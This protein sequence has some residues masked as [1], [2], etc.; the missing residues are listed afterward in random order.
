MSERGPSCI[1]ALFSIGQYF[2]LP[3][4]ARY[5]LSTDLD[6]FVSDY[7]MET[8]NVT[9]QIHA[10]VKSASRAGPTTEQPPILLGLGLSAILPS[11]ANASGYNVL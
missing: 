7:T 4:L 1:Y 9:P 2:H 6:V 10:T 3:S 5:R 8:L 11:N